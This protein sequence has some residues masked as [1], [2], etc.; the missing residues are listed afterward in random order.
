MEAGRRRPWRRHDGPRRGDRGGDGV[1]R[2]GRPRADRAG[3]APPPP[4]RPDRRPHRGDRDRRDG[5]HGDAPRVDAPAP[6]RPRGAE[7][8]GCTPTSPSR[9]E[10]RHVVVEGHGQHGRADAGRTGGRDHAVERAVHAVDVEAGA[11]AG[12]RQ[13]GRPQAGR[14]VAAVV[15]AARRPDRRGRLPARRVQPRAGHRRGGR[16]AARRAT[17]GSSGSASPARRRRPATSA[18][19]RPRTSCRSPPSSAARAR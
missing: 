12:R 6:G 5:R 18:G 16:A 4:G 19:R 17:R 8:S 15:L 7:T 11:G 2:L 9:Y 1:P 3:R 14:V 10:E 13:P